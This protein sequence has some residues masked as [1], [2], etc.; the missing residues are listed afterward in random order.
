M[1]YFKNLITKFILMMQKWPGLMALLAFCSGI[2]SFIL[3]ERKESFSQIIALL[4]LTSWLWLI[5]DNWLRDQ[6]EQRFGIVLSPNFMRFALQMVQQESLF[7]ALPFFLAATTWN[8]PQAAFTCLIALCAFISVVDP[9]YYKKLARHNVLFMVFHNFAL[10][11]VISV[12]L[13]IL[14]HLTTDQSIQIALVTAI[15]L[16]LPS[17]G[18]VMPHARWWRFPLLALLLSALSAGLW[19]LRSWVPPAALRLTDITLAYEVDR[20]QRKPMNSIQHLDTHSLHEQGLYSWSAVK[21]PRGLNEKIFH[22]WVHNKQ[23]VDRIPLNIS[24]GREE[25]YRAWSHKSNFPADSTGKW[26]V[27]VVTS[28]GQLIGLTKFTVSP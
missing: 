17:L 16:T 27:H 14:L 10:F 21:A 28:S 12:T 22:V 1:R 13:P 24:G 15:I 7:F 3:V 18:N 23:V 4:L 9:I 8:H 26:E 11:V 20:Q 5:I 25:G 2:A 19:Q 6:V